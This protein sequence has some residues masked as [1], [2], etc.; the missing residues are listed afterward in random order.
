MGDDVKPVEEAALRITQQ[1]RSG[2]AM[3]YDLRDKV[4]RLTLRI[5]ERQSAT[6][7]GDFRVDAATGN[8]PEAIVI[9][10]WGATRAD[11]LGDAARSWAE[12]RV[13]TGLPAF[14]WESVTR[15]LSAVRAV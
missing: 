14:D 9:T 13:R 10:G 3:V 15:A 12:G 7:P 4:S 6:E 2:R 11:A 5:S 8:G 1:F